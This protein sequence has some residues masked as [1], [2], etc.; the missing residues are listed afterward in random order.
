MHFSHRSWMY[1]LV[2]LLLNACATLPGPTSHDAPRVA[3]PQTAP[4]NNITGF[5]PA[6]ACMD[7]LF[8]RYGAPKRHIM[9]TSIPDQT[10]RNIGGGGKAMLMSTVSEMNKH[11]NAFVYTH[12]PVSPVSSDDPHLSGR[13]DLAYLMEHIKVALGGNRAGVDLPDYIVVASI[14]QLDRGVIERKGGGGVDIGFFG[15]GGS[16]NE[17]VSVLTADFNVANGKNFK[18]MNGMTSNN[19]V[20]IVRRG[21]GGDFNARFKKAGIYFDVSLDQSEGVHAALR[22]LV[23]L[24][25]IEILGQLA[26]VPYQ[27]CLHQPRQ[28][29]VV[30]ITTVRPTIVLSTTRGREAHYRVGETVSL[31]V[32]LSREAHLYCYYRDG[33]EKIWKIFPNDYS[34]PSLRTAGQTLTIPDTNTFDIVAEIPSVI[35][36][37]MCL[38]IPSEKATIVEQ[39]L[40]PDLVRNDLKPIRVRSLNG[41][42]D[43]FRKILGDVDRADLQVR[44]D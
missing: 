41:I 42:A 16:A 6:L 12:L 34:A 44:I 24:S 21:T 1:G 2:A 13:I 38:A 43:A 35:E 30:P 8:Q 4:V 10:G 23:Q 29:P 5:S 39:R 18:I 32:T 14:S 11:S 9:A 15:L 26:G 20:A 31:T 22:N 3:Q 36:N 19:S 37:A 27:Q 33:E 17:I 28:L 40:S 25:M 7:R